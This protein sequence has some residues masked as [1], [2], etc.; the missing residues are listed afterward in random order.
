MK[1]T[2]LVASAAASLLVLSAC[3]DN[4]SSGPLLSAEEAS[5]Q[6]FATKA[7]GSEFDSLLE[8]LQEGPVHARRVTSA[9]TNETYG[10]DETTYTLT[11]N[12]FS[13]EITDAGNRVIVF[14]LNGEEFELTE[15]DEVS[16]EGF[17]FWEVRRDD[18]L[19]VISVFPVRSTVDEL[20]A[21]E[22]PRYAAAFGYFA[23]D[24]SG[25]LMGRNGFAVVGTETRASE[26]DNRGD[27]V[28]TYSGRAQFQ[29]REQGID[30]NDFNASARANIELTA[31]FGANTIAGEGDITQLQLRSGSTVNSDTDP[32]GG[33]VFEE[34]AIQGNAFLGNLNPDADLL[35][36]EPELSAIIDASTY[37]GAF[38]G[39]NGEEVGGVTSG[40]AVIGGD[41]GNE[42]LMYGTF[43]GE[44]VLAV[45]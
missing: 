36:A 31:D 19:T 6:V 10:A 5:R 43:Q 27:A 24:F 2:Y 29:I 8:A 7:D 25:D 20:Y 40:T 32:E 44:E 21:G 18:G 28:A 42:F 12:D 11:Q 35:A 45:E 16:G 37:S 17:G 23:N 38:Y 41:E 26:L 4:G 30:W 9:G 39:P 34:A 22:G 1:P 13:V 33:L 14:T 3:S 15:A